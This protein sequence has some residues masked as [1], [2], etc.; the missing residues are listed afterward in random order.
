VTLT[1]TGPAT[2]SAGGSVTYTLT[3]TNGGTTAINTATFTDALPTGLTLTSESHTSGPDTFTN[4]S[5]GN[6]ASFTA[7]TMGAGNTDVFQIIA[8]TSSTATGGTTLS[9]TATFTSSG[10]SGS[11]N[12]VSTIINAPVTVSLVAPPAL[13]FSTVTQ[14]INLTANVTSA[15]TT[16]NTGSV[17]FTVAGQTASGTVSSGSAT[18]SVTLP[19]G[20]A[21]GSY[22]VTASFSG[23]GF[24]TGS[25]T[26][27]LS[28]GSG[29]ASLAITSALASFGL[30]GATETVTA[31]VTAPGGLNLNQGSVTFT[32]NG[33]TQTANVSNGTATTT[34]SFSLFQ[35]LKVALGHGVSAAFSTTT[36]DLGAATSTFQAPGNLYGFLIQLQIAED[37]IRAFTGG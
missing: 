5:T 11:S 27:N 24:L 19:S 34:F 10:G 26:G 3:F 16:V 25:T 9:N 32:D 22:P 36:G 33:V 2:V 14:T 18:A 15:G 13:T 28:V 31:R 29:A 30:F 12:T 23:T 8:S 7:T 17:T 37:L 20:L 4:T 35:E 6:T 21:A 1:K